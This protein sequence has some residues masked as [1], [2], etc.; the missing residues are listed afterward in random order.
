LDLAAMASIQINGEYKMYY[1]RRLAEGRN[2]MSTLNIVRN[3]LV[4]RVFAIVKRGTPYVDL[5][6]FGA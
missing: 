5:H 4:S 6:R 1:Q 3:K 2:K